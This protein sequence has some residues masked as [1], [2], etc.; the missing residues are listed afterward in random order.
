MESRKCVEKKFIWFN[1]DGGAVEEKIV[2]FVFFFSERETTGT[3]YIHT[4]QRF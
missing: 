2:R 1:Q 4:Y 3:T